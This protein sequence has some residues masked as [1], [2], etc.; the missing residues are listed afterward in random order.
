VA[1][2]FVIESKIGVF[3]HNRRDSGHL[4]PSLW[5]QSPPEAGIDQRPEGTPGWREADFRANAELTGRRPNQAST[6][7]PAEHGDG[8][9]RSVAEPW[10][11]VRAAS[12]DVEEENPLLVADGVRQIVKCW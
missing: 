9:T 4:G 1:S 11:P 5:A 2:P 8:S 6:E 7:A 12:L 3:Q 10:F